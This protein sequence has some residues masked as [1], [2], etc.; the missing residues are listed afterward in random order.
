M[1]NLEL[2][3]RGLERV[4]T[5]SK[6][7]EVLRNSF[8]RS[9]ACET[10]NPRTQCV[11]FSSN[12]SYKDPSPKMHGTRSQGKVLYTMVNVVKTFAVHS[13]TKIR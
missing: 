6:I 8:A 5:A 10:L 2:Q 7:H 13:L 12:D 11:K 9:L 1:E 3:R 4:E